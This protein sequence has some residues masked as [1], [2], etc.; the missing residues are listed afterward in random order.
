MTKKVAKRWQNQTLTD[1]QANILRH[2]IAG[3]E[4][5]AIAAKYNIT[6]SSVQSCLETIQQKFNAPSR[7]ILAMLALYDRLF[8]FEELLPLTVVAL[9]TQFLDQSY[10]A[11]PTDLL[12]SDLID[13]PTDAADAGAP[14]GPLIPNPG[15]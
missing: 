13:S 4:I 9:N 11:Y 6:Y 15:S 2:F 5:H 14:S 7:R 8:T 10:I 12:L 3:W 1:H